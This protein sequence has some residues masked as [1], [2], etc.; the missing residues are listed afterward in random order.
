VLTFSQFKRKLSKH[1]HVF[2]RVIK[3]NTIGLFSKKDFLIIAFFTLLGAG[4]VFAATLITISTPDSQGAAYVAA[5]ACDENVTIRALT[6]PDAATGQLYVATIALS[7]ISQNA[8]TGCGYKIMQIVLKINGQTTYASWSI[9]SSSTDSTFNLTGVTSS[10]GDYYADTVL[11]PFKADGLTNVAIAQIGNFKVFIDISSGTSHTC[12]IVSD[13]TLKCWGY[14]F[15]GQLGDGSSGTGF[16]RVSPVNVRTSSTDATNLTGVTAIGLGQNQSCA[17]LS[18][19]AVKCWGSNDYGQLG[20]SSTVNATARAAP[21]DVSGLSSGVT[22]VE[23]GQ[24]H[25]CALLSTGAVKCWGYNNSGELGDGTSGNNRTYPVS[26]TDLT[27]VTAIAAGNRH[28]CAL[29]SNGTVKCWGYNWKGEL[30]DGSTTART[31][32][33]NVRTSSADASN[34]TGVTAITASQYHT[35]AL[36]SSGTVK[37]WGYN[38]YGQ[39]GDGSQT[40]INYSPVNVRTSSADASNLTGVTAIATSQYHT[41]ALISGGTMKCWGYNY[42]GELGDGSTTVRTSPVSVTGL[43]GVTAISTGD[44]QTCARLSTNFDGI[45]C[46]GWNLYG[47]LG[48]G[49]WG[50]TSN[51]APAVSVR[52]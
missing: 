51:T 17:I 11:T 13:T 32:P 30:G 9:A 37:C 12:A 29:L 14:N 46:W 21:V 22:A 25:T 1:A 34:L 6:A 48:I 8:T 7:D 50:D 35:C 49:T 33:V 20:D 10:L 38:G 18:G 40:D 28:T 5:T 45:K 19:G 4:G 15:E 24:V 26:V 3:L 43:T 47:Q 27:G 23:L 16:N 31:S 41:C 44:F 36:L 39:L 52:P 42:K 2:I